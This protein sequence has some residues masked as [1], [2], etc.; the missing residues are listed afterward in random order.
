M[1]LRLYLRLN[2]LSL[3]WVK[4]ATNLFLLPVFS[5]QNQLAPPMATSTK[6]TP[7]RPASSQQKQ[8]PSSHPVK[9]P[10]TMLAITAKGQGIYLPI[11]HWSLNSLLML[12]MSFLRGMDIWFAANWLGICWGWAWHFLRVMSLIIV[13]LLILCS[14]HLWVL[15]KIGEDNIFSTT[16]HIHGQPAKLIIG[17]TTIE[18][19]VAQKVV[20]SLKLK[21]ELHPH[22][23]KLAWLAIIM[24][25]KVVKRFLPTFVM[26]SF[27]DEV[28]C[29]VL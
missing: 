13:L 19:I 28:L 27:K 10:H 14:L 23:Y 11:A 21:T 17:P 15:R 2:I 1:C 12:K 18:N 24:S 7:T 5:P 3:R 22:P 4:L 9:F 16:C 6:S 20:K 25:V 29:V 26:G 8:P